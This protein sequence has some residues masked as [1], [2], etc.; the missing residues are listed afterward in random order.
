MPT[1]QTDPGNQNSWN[2]TP[3][4][5]KPA[6]RAEGGRKFLC[7][8]MY[9]CQVLYGCSTSAHKAGFTYGGDPR[10]VVHS[11]IIRLAQLVSYFL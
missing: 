9:T 1:V 5:R 2:L 4:L 6:S 10:W 3:F 11:A 7:I 8:Y